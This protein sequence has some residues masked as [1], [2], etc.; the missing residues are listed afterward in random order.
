MYSFVLPRWTKKLNHDVPALIDSA[1]LL[2]AF[3]TV[4]D[5]RRP[6]HN[7]FFDLQAFARR[8]T[9]LMLVLSAIDA[10][11]NV[12]EAAGDKDKRNTS[13]AA[14]DARTK[15]AT[16]APGDGATEERS[17]SGKAKAPVARGET[18]QELGDRGPAELQAT[19]RGAERRLRGRRRSG[20]RRDTPGWRAWEAR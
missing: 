6:S 7:R 12:F 16:A 3:A 2:G 13:R 20:V 11:K 18:T 19:S 15:S 8:P 17:E 9:N 10:L 4:T 5:A 1:L 14:N